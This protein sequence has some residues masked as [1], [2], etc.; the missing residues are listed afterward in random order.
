MEAAEQ[1]VGQILSEG[2]KAQA[3]QADARS[4]EDAEKAVR[5]TVAA[6]GTL[7]ILVNNAGAYPISPV[8]DISEEMWNRVLDLNLKSVFFYSQA[9]ARE[10]IR[11]GHGGK[12]VNMASM[13]GLHPREDMAH[14]TTS[15]AGVIMLTKSLAL[16]MAAH[17]ILINAIAPG[18]VW[19]PG[20]AVVARE[21]EES[22]V[23][24]KEGMDS[25]LARLPLSRFAM[26]DDVARVA[27]FLA[28]SAADYM[29]G[30]V[31]LVDGG[32]QLS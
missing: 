21:A 17:N 26:P 4:A 25:Y 28:S 16:E 9:A 13:E 31:L 10:M 14:Y 12:I 22:G 20:T 7:D 23:S 11:A 19:T 6:F 2:G 18:G 32:Y 3:I 5:A 15:K 30:G 24:L 27:L 1:T 29:T 8:L